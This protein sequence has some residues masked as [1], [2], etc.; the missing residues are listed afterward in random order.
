MKNYEAANP[1]SEEERAAFPILLRGASLR[2]L[3]TRLYDWSNQVEGA[4]VTV[5]DPGE[6][7]DILAFHRDHFSPSLY[8]L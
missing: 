1:L 3:L 7:C 8:G 6:Y 2:F 4:L 5:K